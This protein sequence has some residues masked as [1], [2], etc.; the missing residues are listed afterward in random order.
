VSELQRVHVAVEMTCSVE[1]CERTDRIVRGLCNM[2]YWRLRIRG[3]LPPIPRIT[4]CSIDGCE[5]DSLAR[6]WCSTHYERWRK[7]GT[8]DLL[9]SRL[10]SSAERLAA[11]LVRMPNGCL[12]W[13]GKALR[14]GYGQMEDKGKCVKTHRLAWTLVNGPIPDGLCVLH[15]CDNP[16]CC[17]TDPTEGYP[18]GHLFL[19]TRADNNADMC[20]KGRRR[21]GYEAAQ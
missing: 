2:H 4:Q 9:P 8:T 18:D 11:G 15:H 14:D 13:T 7:H 20:A 5:R 12:E 10:P 6:G 19:G 17:E 21:N 3:D 16:P 1:G